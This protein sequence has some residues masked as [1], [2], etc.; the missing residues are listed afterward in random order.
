[1]SPG[2]YPQAEEYHQHKRKECKVDK[3]HV[4]FTLLW[5]A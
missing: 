3:L 2:T 4:L 5:S 1:M